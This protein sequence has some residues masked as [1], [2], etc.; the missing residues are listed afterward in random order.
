MKI[1]S[2]SLIQENMKIIINKKKVLLLCS[3]SVL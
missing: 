1:L 3:F 2:R